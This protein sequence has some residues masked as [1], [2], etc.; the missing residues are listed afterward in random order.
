MGEK[1]PYDDSSPLIYNG[2]NYVLESYKVANEITRKEAENIVEL[3]YTV[4]DKDEL[5]NDNPDGI[6]DKYQSSLEDL[7]EKYN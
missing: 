6:P 1:I 4:D 5:G 3:Y 7:L 2:H